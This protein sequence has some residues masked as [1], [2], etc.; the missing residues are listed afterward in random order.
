MV[1]SDRLFPLSVFSGVMRV[2]ASVL[3]PSDGRVRTQHMLIVR[4]VSPFTCFGRVGC[5]YFLAVVNNA[6]KYSQASF[7]VDITF[8]FF[9]VNALEWELMGHI[10]TLVYNCLPKR[11]HHFTS[12]AAVCE[13]SNFS[14]FS[15]IL[16]FALCTLWGACRVILLYYCILPF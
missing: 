8:Q 1:F 3:C 10:V 16:V 9:G 2:L 14:T 5:S 15:S 7:F 6:K 12:P 11:L 4:F 13:G